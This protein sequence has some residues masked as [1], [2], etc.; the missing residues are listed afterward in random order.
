MKSLIAPVN[1]RA[2]IESNIAE[3][4]AI[5]ILSAPPQHHSAPP[6]SRLIIKLGSS[7]M[8]NQANKG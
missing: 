3:K 6:K 8:E 1:H 2:L 7:A 4:Q 5:N